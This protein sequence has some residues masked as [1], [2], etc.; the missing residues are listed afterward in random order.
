MKWK[1]STSILP[2]RRCSWTLKKGSQ[3]HNALRQREKESALGPWACGWTRLDWTR[4]KDVRAAMQRED[5]R[6]VREGRPLEFEAQDKRP[7]GASKKRWRD[8][9]KKDLAEAKGT[10]EDAEVKKIETTD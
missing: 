3:A 4:N 1:D 6:E 5:H 7:R 10:G 9:I 2:D 8:V